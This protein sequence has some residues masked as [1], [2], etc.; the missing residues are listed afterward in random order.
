MTLTISRTFA[1]FA[2]LAL[3]ASAVP[4][5]AAD[6]NWEL[7][8][9]TAIVFT[10]GGEYPHTLLNVSQDEDGNLTGNGWY[11]PDHSYTW[12]LTGNIDGDNISYTILYTGAAAGSTYTN[13][14]VIA[15]DGSISGTSSGNCQTFTSPAGTATEIEDEPEYVVPTSKDQC[16]KDGWKTLADN[17]GNA[18]KNQGQCVSFVASAK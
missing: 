16:K 5:F 14:G 11:D 17:E 13:T 6:P 2:A 7:N 3:L 18:F 1:A 8:D 12:T 9:N 4:A 15:S 10:C